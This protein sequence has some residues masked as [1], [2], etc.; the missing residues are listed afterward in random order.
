VS[1]DFLKSA[2]GG[3]AGVLG[4]IFA[5]LFAG[6]IFW[7]IVAPCLLLGL[8]IASCMGIATIEALNP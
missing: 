4:D 1:S 3:V 2:A 6:K 7:F 8:G 5:L